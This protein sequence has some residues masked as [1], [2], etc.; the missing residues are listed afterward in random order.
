V[1]WMLTRNTIKRTPMAKILAFAMPVPGHLYPFVPPLKELARRGHTV[2]LGV[3]SKAS[4]S[5][6]YDGLP[7]RHIPWDGPGDLSAIPATPTFHRFS[8]PAYF[9]RYGQSLADGVSSLIEREE[10]D[11]ILADPKLWGG[12]VAAEASGVPWV[13]IAH[14]PLCFRGMGLDPR[15]P[16]WRPPRSAAGR[17]AHRLLEMAIRL[18]TKEHL[19]EVN[20][21]RSRN[22][23]EPLQTLTDIYMAAPLIL[24]TTAPPLEYPRSDWPSS[25]H[26]V[27]PMLCDP[28]EPDVPLL[29]DLDERPLILVSG[30]TVAPS[31][32]ARGWAQMVLDALADAPFNVLAALPTEKVSNVP[33]AI[34]LHTGLVSHSAILQRAAC[35]ICH[36]GPGIVHKALWHGVP[37]VAIPFALDRFE[38]AQRVES[39]GAGVML[40][41]SRMTPQ[42]VRSAVQRALTCTPAA[43][44]IGQT[45]RA[46]GGP[47]LAAD[48]IE[49]R[50]TRHK[51]LDSR[52]G[53][54]VSM[55]FQP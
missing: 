27:G 10:P 18:E 9:A 50:I 36:G 12:M 8:S 28:W 55:S 4:V 44:R 43:R 34:G 24:A 1:A 5:S 29:G 38:V 54:R 46:T 40:P 26:F 21:V 52:P 49:S 37:L 30:S 31:G 39:A 23:L 16:G 22:S 48:L 15:G 53:D 42:S 14:N 32:N 33:T 51:L 7:L 11:V 6:D 19:A 47:P 25:L 13:S 35:V 45:L 41:L 17:L 3:S 2:S 20:R